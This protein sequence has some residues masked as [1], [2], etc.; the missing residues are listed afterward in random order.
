MYTPGIG[1]QRP[2]ISECTPSLNIS[3]EDNID[4]IVAVTWNRYMMP[5]S[6][7]VILPAVAVT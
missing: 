5:T 6:D 2:A 1:I 4:R 3:S 7:T